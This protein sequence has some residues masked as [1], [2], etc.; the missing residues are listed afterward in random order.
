MR[1]HA[2]LVALCLAA[3]ALVWAEQ[4]IVS[5]YGLRVQGGII[6]RNSNDCDNVPKP[7]G[8]PTTTTPLSRNEHPRMGM[9]IADLPTIAARLTSGGA[10]NS[11]FQ[12]YVDDIED[13]YTWTGTDCGGSANGDRAAQLAFVY[14]VRAQTIT[15]VTFTKT[16]AEFGDEAEECLVALAGS[17]LDTHL[18]TTFAYDWAHDT[19]SSGNR[20]TIVNG[21]KTWITS[22]LSLY[23]YPNGGNWWVPIFS[24]TFAHYAEMCLAAKGDGVEEAWLQT[25]CDRMDWALYGAEDGAGYFKKYTSLTGTQ[26]GC[27]LGSVYCMNYGRPRVAQ[28]ELGW[29]TANGISAATRYTAA[30]NYLLYWAHGMLYTIRPKGYTKGDE[31]GGRAWMHI[32]YPAG[33]VDDLINSE[34][35]IMIAMGLIRTQLQST[36]P[37]HAA[38]AAWLLENRFIES[39][40]P[41]IWHFTRFLGAKNSPSSPSSLSIAGDFANSMGV[42]QWRTGYESTSDALVHVF[43]MDYF[44]SPGASNAGAL[45]INY[46]GPA[47]TIGQRGGHEIDA[48]KMP[49]HNVMG[50]PDPSR[51]T[52]ETGSLDNEDFGYP[53]NYPGT[54]SG[55]MDLNTLMDTGRG[56]TARYRTTAT[57]GIGYLWIDNSRAYNGDTVCDLGSVGN[58]CKVAAYV[59]AV[60]YVPPATPGTDP[61]VLFVYDFA[62]TVSTTYQHRNTFVF[63]SDPTCDGSSSAGPSRNGSTTRK[64]QYSSNTVCTHTLSDGG[65]TGANKTFLSALLPTNRNVVKVEYRYWGGA[66][67]QIEDSYGVM[68]GDMGSIASEFYPYFGWYRIEIIPNV[69]QVTHNFATVLEVCPNTSCS[70]STTEAV[71]G[72]SFVGGRVGA[73]VSV[74]RIG[75]GTTGTFVIPSTGPTVLHVAGISTGST[76]TLTPGSNISINGAGAGVAVSGLTVSAQGTIK[77]TI[78]VTGNGTGAANTVT[79]S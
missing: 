77:V 48:N 49:S 10:W 50:F 12:A 15:G 5:P 32:D 62:T 1:R 44:S 74:H 40:M 24:G 31:P 66:Q 33:G 55:T 67:R 39:S 25:G 23:T 9:T 71:S 7:A 75:D 36:H 57:D 8:C 43:A 20:T 17:S 38:L 26:G 64:T 70:Q 6:I 72:T 47:L 60:S 18:A 73:T 59:R 46:N 52:L 76:R 56:D 78:S 34:N 63:S 68:R 58:S 42:Y 4:G 45:A 19:I 51:T 3:S 2:I 61:L 79:V 11:E 65:F 16:R 29:R 54:F 13:N 28:A 37:T 22:A 27:F 41:R 14:A 35:G 53:R 21:W 30:N 69:S